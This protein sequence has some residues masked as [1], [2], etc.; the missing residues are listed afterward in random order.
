MLYIC[1]DGLRVYAGACGLFL[2][3]R[4]QEDLHALMDAHI[5]IASVCHNSTKALQYI[6]GKAALT[7][8]TVPHVQ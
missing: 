4:S 6:A 7:D 1:Q 5:S 2:F 3:C 8:Q